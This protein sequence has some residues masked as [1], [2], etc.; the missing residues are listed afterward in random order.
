MPLTKTKREGGATIEAKSV[1]V[2]FKIDS[3]TNYAMDLVLRKQHR[4]K[5][6]F[7]LEALQFSLQRFTFGEGDSNVEEENTLKKIDLIWAEHEADRLIKLALNFEHLLTYRE[8]GILHLI[9]IHDYFWE[10]GGVDLMKTWESR[11]KNVE[12][13]ILTNVREYWKSLIEIYTLKQVTKKIPA[14][15]K[16]KRKLKKVS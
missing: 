9:C 14:N 2:A 7:L 5:G 4:N 10:K 13:L 8:R 3:P 11:S 6:D 15:V 12:G 16:P 1:L